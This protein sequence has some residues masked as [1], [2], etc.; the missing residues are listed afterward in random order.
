M[1]ALISPAKTFDFDTPAPTRQASQPEFLAQAQELIDVLQ[2]C[3]D[4]LMQFGVS[5]TKSVES[6]VPG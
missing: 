5:P 3:C 4:W 2:S 1:L 6:Q